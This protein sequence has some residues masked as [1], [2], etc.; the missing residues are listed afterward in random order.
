MA[1]FST[2]G[3]DVAASTGRT[4]SKPNAN[5]IPETVT[6]EGSSKRNV[7]RKG[8]QLD[9]VS[10]NKKKLAS[11]DDGSLEPS[12]T[13]DIGDPLYERADDEN[14]ILVSGDS[15]D[16][17]EER[18]YDSTTGHVV[19]GPLLT[20]GEFKR[21]VDSALLEY[22]ES[23]DCSELLKIIHELGCSEY[24]YH[25][26]RRSVSLACDRTGRECE[27]VSQFLS[28]AY[29][30]ILPSAEM[31]KGFERVFEYIEDLE[32]DAP[33]ASNI[34][35]SFL[36]RALVDEILPP[37]FL[38]DERIESLGGEVVQAA[39][40]MLSRDHQFSRLERI[41]GPGD[42]RPVEELKVEIDALLEEYLVSY[43]LE[44]AERCV[45]ALRAAHF[46]HEL[47]KRAVVTSMDKSAEQQAKVADLVQHLHASQVLSSEHTQ[48]GLS[49]VK[50]K[51]SDLT[52]DAPCAPAVLDFF[53]KALT[54]AKLIPKDFTPT[55]NGAAE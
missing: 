47:V 18:H 39:K 33:G 6:E 8:K 5:P 35:A 13:Y 24:H 15:V 28:A 43:D 32:I 48:Q 9:V 21:R 52:L 20:L 1:T 36:A 29:S 51:L 55:A 53:I 3:P 44:E 4:S 37:S 12:S 27:L 49:K 34:V 11:V 23:T 14:C 41:W 45:R 19:L 7:I 22:F 10:R 26:V 31:A 17:C 54:E 46:H 40:R 25:I 38:T 16:G 2:F 50:A 30:Q 42:G